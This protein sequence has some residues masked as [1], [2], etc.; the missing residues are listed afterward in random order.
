MKSTE[1]LRPQDITVKKAID[2]EPVK[3]NVITALTF[4][5]MGLIGGYF[6]AIHIHGD[7]RAAVIQ[8]IQIVSKEAK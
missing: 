1:Q 7:A 5:I 8:D 4:G 6:I 3:T 2:W